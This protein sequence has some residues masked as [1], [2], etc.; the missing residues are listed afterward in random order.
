LLD[1]P[2]EEEQRLPA[3]YSMGM[4]DSDLLVLRRADG[5]V[6]KRAS[7]LGSVG[8]L[9]N[10]FRPNARRPME[11]GEREARG[12]ALPFGDL[13]TPTSTVPGVATASRRCPDP[14]LG[15]VRLFQPTA[16]HDQATGSAGH[17]PRVRPTVPAYPHAEVPALVRVASQIV[18][19]AF[20][21]RLGVPHRHRGPSAPV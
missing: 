11:W 1:E 15:R 8:S 17:L 10:A 3:G 19:E 16:D 20:R 2:Q 18:G 21:H 9:V 6:V 14:S 13:P 7:F 5:S 12:K 4:E